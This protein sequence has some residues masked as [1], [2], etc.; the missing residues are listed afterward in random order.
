MN[1]K[2]AL[3]RILT[4]IFIFTLVT[5]SLT[6]SVQASVSTNIGTETNNTVGEIRV[7]M[8]VVSGVKMEGF[9]DKSRSWDISNNLAG[10]L[11]IMGVFAM[12]VFIVVVIIYVNHRQ[13]KMLHETLRA[14]VEKGVPIPPGMFFNPANEFMPFR[15]IKRVRND[16]RA[17]LFMASIGAGVVLFIGKLGY[18]FIFLGVAHLILAICEK[19]SQSQD[20]TPEP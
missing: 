18:V 10:M 6:L 16:L 12:F 1:I 19:K 5:A 2:I 15:R 20:Q 4:T 14:M 3:T 7:D 13:N 11:T 9:A 17:G 8:P